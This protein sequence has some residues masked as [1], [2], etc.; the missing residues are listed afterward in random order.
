MASLAT[1][2]VVLFVALPETESKSD[3]G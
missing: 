1:S 2:P 3:P